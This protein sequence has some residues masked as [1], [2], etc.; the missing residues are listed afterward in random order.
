M[1][2]EALQNFGMAPP[3]EL[4]CKRA[5]GLL[6]CFSSDPIVAFLYSFRSFVRSF[7]LSF[8]CSFFLSFFLS[9]ALPQQPEAELER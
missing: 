6:V 1:S 2:K 5:S 9:T 8:F 3:P 7:C 4:L